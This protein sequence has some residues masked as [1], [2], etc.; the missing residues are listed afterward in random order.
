MEPN[1]LLRS[2]AALDPETVAAM[3]PNEWLSMTGTA[4]A[5]A[6]ICMKPP[7]ALAAASA[8]ILPLPLGPPWRIAFATIAPLLGAL[9]LIP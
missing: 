4:R 3:A 7:T 5:S 2:H 8:I 1:S 9:T 6:T